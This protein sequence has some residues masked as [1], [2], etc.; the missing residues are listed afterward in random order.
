MVYTFPQRAALLVHGVYGKRNGGRLISLIVKWVNCSGQAWTCDRIKSICVAAVQIRAGSLERAERLF[1]TKGIRYRKID[2]LPIP[3]GP[4][5]PIVW[6]YCK[7]DKPSKVRRWHGLLRLYTLFVNT[8]LSVNSKEKIIRA[9]TAPGPKLVFRRSETPVK[10]VRELPNLSRL[11]PFSRTHRSWA[12]SEEFRKRLYA[13][14]V[15]SL[16]SEVWIPEA[17]KKLNPCEDL[18][19]AL[20]AEGAQ[21]EFAGHISIVF[22]GGCKDR[23]IAVPN[24]WTQWLFEPLHRHLANMISKCPNS[25][26][27]GQNRG[28]DYLC[29]L[30]DSNRTVWSVDL[31]SATDRFPL[32]YQAAFLQ[33]IGLTPYAEAFIELS[34]HKWKFG[35]DVVRYGAG[36]P[37][38]VQ[39]SYPLFHLSNVNLLR[40]CAKLVGAAPGDFMVQGD[41]VIIANERLYREYRKRLEAFGVEVSD[42]K[43]LESLVV[44]QFAGF[45][46]VKLSRGAHAYRPYKWYNK[47]Q[48]TDPVNASYAFGTSIK[49]MSDEWS[50]LHDLLSL[51][52]HLRDHDLSPLIEEEDEGGMHDYGLSPYYLGSL[53]NVAYAERYPPDKPG[54]P[55]SEFQELWPVSRYILLG[56]QNVETPWK[57]VDSGG[58]KPSP[59]TKVASSARIA[60]LEKPTEVRAPDLRSLLREGGAKSTDRLIREVKRP[61]PK[62]IVDNEPNTA[63]GEANPPT[64]I[65]EMDLF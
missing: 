62:S 9:I 2:G 30:L 10:T 7:S 34:Q 53:V 42:P 55:D 47:S 58:L 35:D 25:T 65:G 64:S 63:T 24:C 22:D 15:L 44:G 40:S 56:Q 14:H 6:A 26:V 19:R 4:F 13:Y 59:A 20:L 1:A 37:M 45:T 57:P 17:L 32:A 23:N 54:P 3:V 5:G 36:Q 18:R 31:T 33:A 29:R 61:I 51:T 38:G 8:E 21:E 52:W 12:G 41:D 43:T 60:E 11:H 50:K 49:R 28:A 39:G 16:L 27:F 46:A 48:R